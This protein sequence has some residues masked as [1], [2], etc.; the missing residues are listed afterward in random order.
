[1]RAAYRAAYCVLLLSLPLLSACTARPTQ[2]A[3]I[4]TRDNAA[5]ANSARKDDLHLEVLPLPASVRDLMQSLRSGA[6]ILADPDWYVWG[7]SI[8]HGPDGQYHLFTAR[9]PRRLGFYAWLTHSEIA[10]AIAEH[11]EGPYRWLGPALQARGAGHWDQ[12]TVHNPR[13]KQ[14]DGKYYLYYI[15]TNGDVSDDELVEIARVGY[16]HPKWKLLRENQRTGV[17]VADSLNGPWRRMDHPIIE[18]A[19]PITTLTVNPAIAR[20]PDGT[21]FMIIKGDKPGTTAFVRNQ[22]LATADSPIGPF[23]IQPNPVI[24]SFDSEDAAMWFDHDRN[25][26]YVT[27]HADQQIG[28]LTSA[29]GYVWTAA[30]HSPLT[31]KQIHFDNGDTLTPRRMERPFVWLDES[32]RPALLFVAV[33]VGDNAFNLHLP[34]GPVRE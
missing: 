6:H 32:G 15:A 34:L 7:A 18:P 1:M 8:V 30:A 20:G 24:D 5:P 23:H 17:A 10:H 22:A 28:L 21:Y 27:F 25:R 2:P 4:T 16:S 13:I 26:F 9:W 14:F 33:K 12:I 31:P 3:C 11:P 19:G 29:D